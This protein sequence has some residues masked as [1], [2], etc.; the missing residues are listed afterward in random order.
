[1]GHTQMTGDMLIKTLS[2]LPIARQ[3]KNEAAESAR[4]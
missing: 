3:N 2:G 1:M 4:N